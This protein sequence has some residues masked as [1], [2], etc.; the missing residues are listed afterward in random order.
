[1]RIPWFPMTCAITRICTRA[2][3]V[4]CASVCAGACVHGSGH[5]A[6]S[7]PPAQADASA[8][9]VLFGEYYEQALA[10]DPVLATTL[11]DHRY[12]NHLAIDISDD[13][14]GR[15]R[16]IYTRL[17]ARLDALAATAFTGD[18]GLSL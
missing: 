13:Y 14:R 15:Q 11:G 9:H 10:L 5:V 2:G 18:D 12:D 7:P 3:L 1:M 16:E 4:V 8:L 6:L 17:L